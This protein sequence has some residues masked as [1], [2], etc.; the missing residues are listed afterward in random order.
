MSVKHLPTSLLA[1]Q[2]IFHG[3]RCSAVDVTASYL[4]RIEELNTSLNAYLTVCADRARQAASSIDFMR[5]HHPAGLGPLAGA[6]VSIKDL[7]DTNFAPTT[8]GSRVYLD[9]RPSE[10]AVVV[11]RLERAHAIILGKTHLHEFAYGIT[12]E[13]EHFGPARNPV[14]VSRMTGG[15]SGGSAA[16]VRSNMALASVGTDTGGSIRIPASLTGIVGFKPSHGL[17][18]TAGVYPL[19]PS[20]DHV[21]PLTLT[22]TDAALLVDI[23]ADLHGNQSLVERINRWPVPSSPI[24]VGVP[25]QLIERFATTEVANAFQTVLSALERANYVQVV[26]SID[27]DEDDVATHQFAIMS[28]EAAAV[29]ANQ[30]K[31]MFDL[32]SVDVRERLQHAQQGTT[33]QA[34]MRGIAFQKVFRSLVDD[35][36]RDA[37][38]LMLPTTPVAAPLLGTVTI[39]VSQGDEHD[40]RSLMTRFTN[41]WNLSG[42]P[43]ISLPAGAIDGLPFGLQLVGRYGHDAELLWR[44]KHVETLL[45][46]M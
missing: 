16:S 26:K 37:D 21:G 19:A 35:W 24:R 22:V 12:N 4:R 18:P 2:E 20:L 23:M 6:P 9:K 38:V 43:A 29:H 7:I 39:T 32:Y 25:K 34:Y 11:E 45:A 46:S 36:L 42:V 3:A 13:S 40:L 28:G 5:E 17:V 41:P 31:S 33:T 15:S 44:A 1:W 14:D 10:N 30:L 8:Y 27:F